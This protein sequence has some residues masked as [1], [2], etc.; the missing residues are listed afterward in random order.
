CG[1]SANGDEH[2]RNTC[3]IYAPPRGP[4]VAEGQGGTM[5]VVHA[6]CA[7]LDVHKKTVV[8]CVMV[9][10]ETGVQKETRTYRTMTRPLRE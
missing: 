3:C 9:S 10:S 2:V 1:L 6:R 8:A 5:D 4:V 7:G